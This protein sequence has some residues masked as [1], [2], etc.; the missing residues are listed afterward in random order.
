MKDFNDC[1]FADVFRDL[2]SSVP[3]CRRGHVGMTD[4]IEACNNCSSCPYYIT[5]PE[6]ISMQN[7]MV[8]RLVEMFSKK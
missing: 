2:G 1:I 6:I 5:R 8:K 7:F 3:Y 4:A